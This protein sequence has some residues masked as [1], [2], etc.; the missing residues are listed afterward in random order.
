MTRLAILFGILLLAACGA[1]DGALVRGETGKPMRIV[2]LDYCADQYVL[3]LADREQILAI[4]P[5]ATGDFSYMREA[6]RGVPTV[7]AAAEDD[8]QRAIS[9]ISWHR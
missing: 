6:A 4:S 1:P 2:S 9:S 8:V 3:K 5:D 7:R